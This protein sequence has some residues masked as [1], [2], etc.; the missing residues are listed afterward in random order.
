M[1]TASSRNAPPSAGPARF[2]T[3]A[4]LEPLAGH[5]VATSD[6][7]RV[8]QEMID[9]FAEATNDRQWIHVDV[10]RAR[11]AFE[12]GKT[13][14]HGF[15]IVSLLAP[16]F[17]NTVQVGGT[18]SS[19][20]YGFNRLR[21]TA[22]VI[23]DSAI[24]AHFILKAYDKIEGGA[25]LTWSVTIEIAGLDKPAMVAEWLMRRYQ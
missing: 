16:L 7:M 12:H 24:R 14:A 5:A 2:A 11:D 4:Q 3:I 23:C 8:T 18:A 1:E 21:F 20:N 9:R 25:Q 13:I 22:P 6:W 19:I 10:A 17:E 15:L